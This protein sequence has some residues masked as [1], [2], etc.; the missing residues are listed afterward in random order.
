MGLNNNNQVNDTGEQNVENKPELWRVNTVVDST[1]IRSG[2]GENND[3]VNVIEGQQAVTIVEKYYDEV[4]YD[5]WGKLK[6]GLGW[7]NP[8]DPGMEFVEYVEE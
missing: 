6:S 4:T 2:P 3:V 5:T 7:I 1:D 8:S